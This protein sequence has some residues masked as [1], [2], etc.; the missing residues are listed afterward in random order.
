MTIEQARAGRRQEV[1]RLMLLT[2]LRQRKLNDTGHV[3]MGGVRIDVVSCDGKMLMARW[4]FD[5]KGVPEFPQHIHPGIYET[6]GLVSGYARFEFGDGAVR[7]LVNHGDSVTV[8]PG[9][10]HRVF[11]QEGEPS[12]GWLVVVPPDDGLIPR[13]EFGSCMLGGTMKCAGGDDCVLRIFT[14]DIHGPGGA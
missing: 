11:W 7:E 10:P 3:S 14:G 13:D 6:V 1:G 9:M 8:P 2:N 4:W 12:E 5:G